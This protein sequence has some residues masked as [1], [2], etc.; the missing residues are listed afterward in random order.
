MMLRSTAGEPMIGTDAS[1]EE[2]LT[3]ER[4]VFLTTFLEWLTYQDL[5]ETETSN[6]G[7]EEK[8]LNSTRFQVKSKRASTLEEAEEEM[9]LKSPST[10][11]VVFPLWGPSE[12]VG[13]VRLLDLLNGQIA[14][15]L[16]PKP[17]ADKALS[18]M[19]F[20]KE[21]NPQLFRTLIEDPEEVEVDE[22]S[23]LLQFIGAVRMPS[24][25][26]FKDLLE[27][28]EDITNGSY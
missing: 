9:E 14:S 13:R 28:L 4:P 26:D 19:A 25:F 24:D 23:S 10:P 21:G 22:L 15:T 3:R 18:I 1:L 6:F 5:E 17:L 8:L 27:E 16:L 20:L 12:I 2:T 7:K 11:S